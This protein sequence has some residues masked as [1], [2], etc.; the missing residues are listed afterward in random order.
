MK[1]RKRL[2][3]GTLGAFEEVFPTQIDETVLLVLEALAGQQEQIM[4]LQ[5]EIEELKGG[6]A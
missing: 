1:V 5:A 3:D 2:P 6:K 4:E